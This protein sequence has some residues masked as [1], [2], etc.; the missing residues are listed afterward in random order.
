MTIAFLT[1]ELN[2]ANIAAESY[3]AVVEEKFQCYAALIS[4][5]NLAVDTLAYYATGGTDRRMADET[6]T[7]LVEASSKQRKKTT[8]RMKRTKV[9]QPTG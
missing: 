7:L 6:L 9:S 2:N 4:H 5:F 8:K 3:K 1:R